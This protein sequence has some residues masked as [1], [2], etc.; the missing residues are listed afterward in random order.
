[1][2]RRA[3]GFT[4]IEMMVALSICLAIM[5]IVVPIFQVTTRTV[6][7]VER[8]LAVYEAARNILDCIE[9]ELRQAMTNERGET[10]CLKGLSFPDNDPFTPPGTER[11]YQSRRESHSVHFLRWGA[12]PHDDYSVSEI[13]GGYQFPRI[14]TGHSSTDLYHGAIVPDTVGVTPAKRK[15]SMDD[16]S[17]IEL[18]ISFNGRGGGEN[19]WKEPDGTWKSKCWNEAV[20]CMSPGSEINAPRGSTGG[21]GIM[22]VKILDFAC[23]YWDDAEG[24]FKYPDDDTAIYFSPMPRAVRVTITVADPKKRSRITLSRI[25]QLLCGIGAGT[26]ENPA[27]PDPKYLSPSVYN[28]VKDLK[29]VNTYLYSGV[30]NSDDGF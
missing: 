20:N 26:V 29:Q 22:S 18:P 9:I 10:F 3:R 12:Q 2:Q 27:S 1:M 7:S 17:L 21:A 25:I 5:V 28:R 23:A 8:R 15:Y 19:R 13:G 24:K 14:W 11:F 4:L 30:N 6:E 16:V